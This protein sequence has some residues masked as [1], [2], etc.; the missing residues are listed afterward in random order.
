MY[1]NGQPIRRATAWTPAPTK[2]P[3]PFMGDSKR[4]GQ[5][6]GFWD[7][8]VLAF[9]LDTWTSLTSAYLGWGFSRRGNN[10]STFWYVVAAVSGFKA[11]YDLSR[12][13]R[14]K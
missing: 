12:I 1:T 11:I 13:E 5:A 8:P 14:K 10:W 3:S 4:L 2:L 9:T 6:G 7:S